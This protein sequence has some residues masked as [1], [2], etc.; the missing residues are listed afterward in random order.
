MVV[1]YLTRLRTLDQPGITPRRR[2]RFEPRAGLSGRL[3]LPLTPAALTATENAPRSSAAGS[4]LDPAAPNVKATPTVEATQAVDAT[5]AVE[6]TQT[7]EATPTIEATQTFEATPSVRV[8]A[9]AIETR[10]QPDPSRVT[11]SPAQERG[12]SAG[13]TARSAAHP[14]DRD[15]RDTAPDA[16]ATPA[17]RT[18]VPLPARTEATEVSYAPAQPGRSGVSSTSDELYPPASRQMPV[19]PRPDRDRSIDQPVPAPR[20]RVKETAMQRTAAA[21]RGAEPIYPQHASAY[22]GETPFAGGGPVVSYEPSDQIPP[23]TPAAQESAVTA[24]ARP[25]PPTVHVSIGRVEVT[26]PGPAPA[27]PARRA[28]TSPT[29]SLDAYLSARRSRQVG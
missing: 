21:L 18:A 4:A 15:R 16:L 7:V 28:P 14:A 17:Q 27:P 5:Q 26:G 19:G 12:Y 24:P 29:S 6:A 9:T 2:S 25:E 11:P 23:P 10:T 8:P 1:P 3:E 20:V 22:R 13:R